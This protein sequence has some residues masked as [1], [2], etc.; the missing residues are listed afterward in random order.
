MSRRRSAGG[1]TTA[2]DLT[3]P[4][5]VWEVNDRWRIHEPVRF[6]DD[7]DAYLAEGAGGYSVYEAESMD[8]AIAL[9]ARIPA[10][11]LGGAVAKTVASMRQPGA[12]HQIAF[13]RRRSDRV[14][15][16]YSASCLRSADPLVPGF[17]ALE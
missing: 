6:V 14:P 16:G 15:T 7:A 8:A 17:G 10:A 3:D 1:K 5:T 4:S 13:R 12:L 11:R 9:A 2:R